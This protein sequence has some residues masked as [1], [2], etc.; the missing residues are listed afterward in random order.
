[1]PVEDICDDHV[2]PLDLPTSE[3]CSTQVEFNKQSLGIERDGLP[4]SAIPETSNFSPTPEQPYDQTDEEKEEEYQ[5]YRRQSCPEEHE[6]PE[7][8]PVEDFQPMDQLHKRSE[9]E[10]EADYPELYQ[11]CVNDEQY[12]QRETSNF[13]TTKIIASSKYRHVRKSSMAGYVP[14]EN[15]QQ[16]TSSADGSRHFTQPADPEKS[17]E[18]DVDVDGTNNE[19]QAD[20]SITPITDRREHLMDGQDA[21]IQCNN[22]EMDKTLDQYIEDLREANKQADIRKMQMN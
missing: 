15:E 8:V 9:A 18:I 4:I 11:Q 21:G 7:A 1:M 13:G 12:Q 5:Q 2:R 17:D 10:A 19:N 6:A 14:V 3:Q 16:N 20:R 22:Q